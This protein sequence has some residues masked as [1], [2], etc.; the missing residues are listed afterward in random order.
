MTCGIAIAV[1]GCGVSIDAMVPDSPPGNYR[2]INESL[3]VAD[4]TSSYKPNFTDLPPVSSEEFKGA[5]TKALETSNLFA[6]A[7]GSNADL[8]LYAAIRGQT[9]NELIGQGHRTS[10]VVEYRIVR[11]SSQQ[12]VWDETYESQSGSTALGARGFY[13]SQEGSVRQ[14]LAAFLQGISDGWKQ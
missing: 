1:S 10:I 5:L 14:N 3:T 7:K 2:H 11:T 8:I 4:V 9:Y 13:H 6:S 12:A